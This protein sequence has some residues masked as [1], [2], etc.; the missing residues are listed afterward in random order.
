M[1]LC[2][3][4]RVI[5]KPPIPRIQLGVPKRSIAERL[6]EI[7]TNKRQFCNTIKRGVTETLHDLKQNVFG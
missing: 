3:V 5:E 2:A 4:V 6:I 7:P 1:M